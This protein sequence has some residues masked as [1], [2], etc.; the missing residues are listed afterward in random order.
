MMCNKGEFAIGCWQRW[1][2]RLQFMYRS[3]VV[4]RSGLKGLN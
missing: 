3:R 1:S 4:R 2:C